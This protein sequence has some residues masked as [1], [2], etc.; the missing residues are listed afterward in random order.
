MRVRPQEELS[1]GAL[2]ATEFRT[3][4]LPEAERDCLLLLSFAQKYSL[5]VREHQIL[6]GL[7]QGE[8]RYPS[9]SLQA[10]WEHLQKT[11]LHA[12]QQ[13]GFDGKKN[14][15][16]PNTQGEI[17]EKYAQFLDSSEA[18]NIREYLLRLD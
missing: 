14:W 2:V 11:L 4:L 3:L 13:Y 8:L 6:S 5:I 10:E 1:L 15:G 9:P 12:L 18:E 7:V 17:W 16:N